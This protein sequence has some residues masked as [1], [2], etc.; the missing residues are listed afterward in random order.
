MYRR[1]GSVEAIQQE[2]DPENR[3]WG[4]FPRRRLEVEELRD[5]ILATA[6]TLDAQLGGNLLPTKNRQYVTSTA[7]VNPKIYETHRRTI[8]LP[9]VRSALFDVFQAFDFADPNVSSGQRQTTTIAPQALFLMNSAF[10]AQQ[11]L[12]WADDLLS[13]T[14]LKDEWRLQ[15]AYRRALGRDATAD[16]LQ[17][18]TTF[19]AEYEQ[20]LAAENV[21]AGEARRRAW[22]SFCRALLST[23]EFVYVE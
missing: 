4:R 7:N 21:A 14:S 13:M 6:G 9:I 3:L 22:Q 1:S 16:D 23:N 10:V 5:A 17:R 11:S 19:L 2:L 18:A 8:Y 12:A 20:R 15:R